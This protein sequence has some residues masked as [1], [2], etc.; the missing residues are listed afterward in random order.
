MDNIIILAGL[1]YVIYLINNNNNKNDDIPVMQKTDEDVGPDSGWFA[2]DT[3]YNPITPNITPI[4]ADVD[5]QPDGTYI[6]N[7]DVI[8]NINLTN[9]D[10]IDM[11]SYGYIVP[12][13]DNI[14]DQLSKIT[15]Y[16]RVSKYNSK[17]TANIPVSDNQHIFDNYSYKNFKISTGYVVLPLNYEINYYVAS[18][19][20]S[21]DDRSKITLETINIIAGRSNDSNKTFYP[22][23]F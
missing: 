6:T 9:N 18:S 20:L 19:S 14:K 13:P 2:N 17:I 22:E 3:V 21:A 23:W 16:Q 4:S 5:I 12:N 11:Q 10:T 8:N 7:N 1:G 15:E